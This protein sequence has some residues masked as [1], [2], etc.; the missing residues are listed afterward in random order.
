M[1]TY[2]K[3]YFFQPFHHWE[4]IF[5]RY[6]DRTLSSEKNTFCQNQHKCID[7]RNLFYLSL[8]VKISLRTL[9]IKIRHVVDEDLSLSEQPT[10]SPLVFDSEKKTLLSST[11]RFK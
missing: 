1:K 7:L 9:K 4:L 5:Q 2:C 10:S 11:E 8:V 3:L 6:Q